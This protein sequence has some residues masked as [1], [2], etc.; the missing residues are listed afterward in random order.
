[1]RMLAEIPIEGCIVKEKIIGETD[2]FFCDEAFA[3]NPESVQS[4]LKDASQAVENI[5]IHGSGTP[6]Q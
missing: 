4:I 5:L 2:I 3:Q 1:M 6:D